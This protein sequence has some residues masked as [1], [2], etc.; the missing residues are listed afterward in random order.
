MYFTKII[1]MIKRIS[2]YYRTYGMKRMSQMLIS[3]VQDK[4]FDVFNGTDT[5]DAVLV[6]DLKYDEEAQEHGTQYSATRDRYLSALLSHL[7]PLNDSVIV[8]FGSGKAK[9]LFVAVKHHVKR[10]VGVEIAPELHEIAI[11]NKDLILRKGKNNNRDIQLL[12]IDARQ[13]KFSGDENILYF[14]RPFDA[15]IMK[16]VLKNIVCSL[17]NNPRHTVLVICHNVYEDLLDQ[18]PIF[19]KRE[20]F[21]YGS[22]DF[23]LYVNI[24]LT[25]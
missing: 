16:T 19:K 7:R 18:H 3:V 21:S 2:K 15:H 14:Y 22:A 20:T 6:K 9:V 25:G 10:A 13:Y 24:V 17:E 23:E 1:F 5:L 8:D 12:N 11:N 4:L